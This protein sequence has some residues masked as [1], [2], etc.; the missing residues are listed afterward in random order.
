MTLPLR[1]IA[2]AASVGSMGVS[3]VW[4]VSPDALV[5]DATLP[6]GRKSIVPPPSAVSVRVQW[7]VAVGEPTVIV[8]VELLVRSRVTVPVELL[9]SPRNA[10]VAGG[11]GG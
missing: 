4:S 5:N 10:P 9:M 11:G 6:F 1:L 7:I 8:S 3:T 2:R